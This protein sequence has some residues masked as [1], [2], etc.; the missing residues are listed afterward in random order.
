DPYLRFEKGE[1]LTR[2]MLELILKYKFPVHMITKSDLILRDMDLL[3]RIATEAVIPKHVSAL[4]TGTIIS[5]SFST[6][7]DAVCKQFEPGATL[8]SIRLAAAETLVKNGFLVGI[9]MMPLLPYISDTTVSLNQM[10][11]EFRRIRVKYILPATITLF[12]NAAADSRTQVFRAIQKHYPELL[13]K[14]EKLLG[15]NDYL[16]IHYNLAFM[17]KMEEMSREYGIKLSILEGQ[18]QLHSHFK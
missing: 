5:F 14:Y 6:V 2:G 1:K 18:N 7:D 12:G 11:A 9:S 16:P 8:T 15:K 4:K 17:A 10:F 3:E 13:P